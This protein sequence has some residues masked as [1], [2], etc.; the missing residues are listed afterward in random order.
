MALMLKTM[1]RSIVIGAV[2]IFMLLLTGAS[3]KEYAST[4]TTARKFC[5]GYTVIEADKGIDCY[6]DTIRL[7]KTN[8]YFERAI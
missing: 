5:R 1:I 8:G 3:Q 4:T 7:V 6:G 2:A